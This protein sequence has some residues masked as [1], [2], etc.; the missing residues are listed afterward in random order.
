MMIKYQ[1]EFDAWYVSFMEKLKPKETTEKAGQ[2]STHLALLTPSSSTIA[3]STAAPN[4]SMERSPHKSSTKE[5][6]DPLAP[7]VSGLALDVQESQDQP[8]ETTEISEEP[9]EVHKGESDKR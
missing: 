7:K 3:S 6:V 9:I 1:E 2:T 4:F 5:A 8:K